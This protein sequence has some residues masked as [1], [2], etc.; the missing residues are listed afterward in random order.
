MDKLKKFQLMEKIARELEDV[1]NSQQAVLEKIGKIEVDN[2][3]L[4]D[5]NIE[6]TIPD[7]YQRT[8]DNSDAIKALLESFQDETAEFG[9]K[10]NVGKLLEQQQIN[11]IK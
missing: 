10:N 5:K 8:S 9:E 11:S 1:R 4:G 3:E 7:I 6:K 2:I